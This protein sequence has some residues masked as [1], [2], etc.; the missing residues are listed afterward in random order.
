MDL[1]FVNVSCNLCNSINY[2]EFL[3]REDLNTFI[4]GIFRLVRC[5]ECGLVYQNPRP[6]DK[7]WNKIYPEEYDQYI[8]TS[9]NQTFV[10]TSFRTYGLIKRIR[11]IERFRT[12]GVLCDLGCSTGDFLYE[13]GNHLDW[14]AFGI[15]PSSEA[16]SYARLQ[17]LKVFSGTLEDNIDEIPTIDVLTMWNV[18]EHLSDPVK[19]LKIINGKMS[20]NGLL[21]FT[22]PNLDSLDAQIFRKYWIGYE[23]PRHFYVFS[24]KT[25]NHLLNVTGFTLVDTQCLFGSHAAAMSSLRFWLRSKYPHLPRTVENFF[26]GPIARI[27]LSPFFYVSDKAKMS[28]PLTIFARKR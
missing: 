4:P 28:S 20:S 7:D 18:I 21:V 2:T 1:E 25:I 22:T 17:G 13:L 15:E 19:T 8:P 6:S 23:L 26:F 5:T 27:I 14:E 12:H 11:S 3:A 24:M 9:A 10:E 16:S